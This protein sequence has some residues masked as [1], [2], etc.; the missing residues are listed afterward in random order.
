MFPILISQCYLEPGASF[1]C[2]AK[3]LTRK[4]SLTSH[5]SLTSRFLRKPIRTRGRNTRFWRGACSLVPK[6]NLGTRRARESSNHNHHQ[7]YDHHFS[8]PLTA[9]RF[10]NFLVSS[11]FHP[12][13]VII[14][15]KLQSI[16]IFYSTLSENL[17]FYCHDS[18]YSDIIRFLVASLEGAGVRTF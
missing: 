11:A 6:C 14:L 3:G 2:R 7:N 10:C 1:M 15:S 8:A 5:S 13:A 12:Q 17:I 4:M 18:F 9:L 16:D